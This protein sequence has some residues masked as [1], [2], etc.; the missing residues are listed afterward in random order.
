MSFV[1]SSE[2]S[3]LH[4]LRVYCTIIQL[5]LGV[6]QGAKLAV[7]PVCQGPTIH[8]Y[9]TT[10]NHSGNELQPLPVALMNDNKACGR[11]STFWLWFR[12]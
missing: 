12:P 7:S 11:H 2:K 1:S 10:N 3:D 4:T 6:Q 8:E 5:I 9:R